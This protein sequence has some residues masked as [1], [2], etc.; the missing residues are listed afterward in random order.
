V[1]VAPYRASGSVTIRFRKAGA[2]PELQWE[3]YSYAVFASNGQYR[4]WDRVTLYRDGQRVWG[5]EPGASGLSP[6]R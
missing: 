4:P 5:E 6:R 1:A 2:D 3:D